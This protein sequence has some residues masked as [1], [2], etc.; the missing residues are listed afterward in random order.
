MDN[1]QL[2]Q[3]P[4][5][6]VWFLSAEELAAT[7]A[8]LA[9]IIGR[10]ARKGFTGS[11]DLVAVAATRTQ[12]VSGGFPVTV[13][14]FAVTISGE[15]PRYAGWR[16]VAS[17]DAVDGGT[18][19][20]YPPGRD[21]AFR[22]TDV[23]AGH[24]DHCHTRR[25]RRRTMLLAHDDTGQ[26]L[27]VGT[28]CLK[29]FLGHHLSPV[30][31]AADD[32][33]AELGKGLS[34]TP[35]AWDLTSV[36]TYAWAAVQALGWTPASASEPGRTPTRDV[37][38]QVLTQQ[39]AADRLLVELA[40]HLAEGR[41]LAPRIIDT[42]VTGLSGESG[43]EAN[44]TAVLRGEAVDARHLGLAVSAIAAHQRLL[45]QRQADTAHQDAVA[46]AD[47]VG[48]VGD[49][50][51]LTGTVHNL[52]RVDGYTYHSPD[53]ILLILDCGTAVAKMTTAASWAYQV[54]VGD[55]LTVTG[56][57]KAHS[58]WNGVK[59]TVLTRP[60]KLDLPA[61]TLPQTPPAPDVTGRERVDSP[62]LDGASAD[63]K[64]FPPTPTPGLALPR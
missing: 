7:R 39:R 56:T 2:E 63:R 33:R 64:A 55:P 24:C 36:L 8:K 46:A 28:S 4:N 25:A 1:T 21:A 58:V 40:P 19:L 50:I 27:Q 62:R 10:A 9:T 51:T 61:A 35:T 48:V 17:V 32:V 6:P 16:F 30:F 12:P 13:H 22:N 52:I 26:L 41:R 31:L 42:L 5:P 38:R 20:R 37:V 57:V 45:E 54:K 34:A 43:Y 49:K 14:G 44:L 23:V 3:R 15:A 18:I 53:S 29:D 11:I 60:K 59:Q 47:H